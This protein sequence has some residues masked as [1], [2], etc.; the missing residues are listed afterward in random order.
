MWEYAVLHEHDEKWVVIQG[1][2]VAKC[3]VEVVF[4]D[5][6]KRG[7]QKRTDAAFGNSE[8]RK[9]SVRNPANDTIWWRYEEKTWNAENPFWS[10]NHSNF[11]DTVKTFKNKTHKSH[12]EVVELF[13][14]T[15]KSVKIVSEG[16]TEPMY[17]AETATQVLNKAGLDGWEL[18]G[19]VPSGSN[20]MLRRE[21]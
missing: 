7:W 4:E 3:Y 10:F 17:E 14:G 16:L 2:G 15:P 6:I 11:E 12:K 13:G 19:N 21:I 20:R 18:V 8:T 5:K 9:K 1:E